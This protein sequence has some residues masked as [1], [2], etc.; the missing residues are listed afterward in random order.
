MKTIAQT[1]EERLASLPVEQNGKPSA[2][3]TRRL[4]LETNFQFWTTWLTILD[5]L[6]RLQ[7]VGGGVSSIFGCTSGLKSRA[8]II[9]GMKLIK[10]QLRLPRLSFDTYFKLVHIL[11]DACQKAEN[12]DDVDIALCALMVFVQLELGVEPDPAYGH[13]PQPQEPTHKLS[14]ADLSDDPAVAELELEFRHDTSDDFGTS[15]Y[16]SLRWFRGWEEV[17]E[18]AE[19]F[20]QAFPGMGYRRSH[21]VRAARPIFLHLDPVLGVHDLELFLSWAKRLL[22]SPLQ[23]S[24]GAEL[25]A[26]QPEYKETAEAA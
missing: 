18:D 8:E 3:Q 25:S 17:I 13:F 15:E 1:Y 10:E 16:H 5:P 6:D 22:K 24:L 14:D 23:E 19:K 12:R 26:A 7:G 2:S 20:E 9:Q 4:R 21:L 11:R